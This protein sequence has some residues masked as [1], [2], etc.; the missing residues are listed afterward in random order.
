MSSSA[1]S[2][3]KDQPTAT[4]DE[5]NPKASGKVEVRIA[6]AL[7]KRDFEDARHLLLNA[8]TPAEA[9]G[10]PV[11]V[12]F[13]DQLERTLALMEKN[14]WVDAF[15]LLVDQLTL[16]APPFPAFYDVIADEL[17][18][19]NELVLA[20]ETWRR[21]GSSTKAEKRWH[22]A[23]TTLGVSA[24][25]LGKEVAS[26][27]ADFYEELLTDAKDD[28]SP[29]IPTPRALERQAYYLW[30]LQDLPVCRDAA[31]RA[32]AAD[33]QR[34]HA[35]ALLAAATQRLEPARA[36]AAHQAFIA[37]LAKAPPPEHQRNEDL[38]LFAAAAEIYSD[39]A[40]AAVTRIQAHIA[41]CTDPVHRYGLQRL[42]GGLQE[43]AAGR[44]VHAALW[45]QAFCETEDIVTEAFLL[46]THAQLAAAG[47][48]ALAETLAEQLRESGFLEE[49]ATA[50]TADASLDPTLAHLRAQHA[51]QPKDTNVTFYLAVALYLD[52]A[53]AEARPLVED[54]IAQRPEWVLPY[55]L[56]ALLHEQ[57]AQVVAAVAAGLAVDPEDLALHG[58]RARYDTHPENA[59]ASYEKAI[60]WEDND[61]QLLE[62]KRE[63]LHTLERWPQLAEHLQHMV[64]LTEEPVRRNQLLG[65]FALILE[66]RL[67]N[68]RA[69]QAVREQMAKLVTQPAARPKTKPKKNAGMGCLPIGIILFIA[70]VIIAIVIVSGL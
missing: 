5:N 41:T 3:P 34:L 12:L 69:A 11:W 10:A 43:L 59:L 28:A 67:R 18:S 37:A 33:D 20:A 13:R 32:V 45:A 66:Q 62:A 49:K 27:C 68:P 46:R 8:S 63:H 1:D 47:D 24:A 29:L 26:I 21:I 38:S 30:L 61:E 36:P 44:P 57:A 40:A 53:H 2:S 42:C 58:L 25:E 65:E 7:R 9:H 60:L 51:Q 22:N 48:E 23:L 39:D 31:A 4:D 6:R 16:T 14:R 35:R 15:F 70:M 52:D 55:E 56:L 17:S 64:N 54:L 19:E 50:E